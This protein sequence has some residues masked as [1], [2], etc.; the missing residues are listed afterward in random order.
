M[1][2]A[3][4]DFDASNDHIRIDAGDGR[5]TEGIALDTRERPSG[6]RWTDDEWVSRID[7][8]LRQAANVA[9]IFGVHVRYNQAWCEDRAKKIGAHVPRPD[10]RSDIAERDAYMAIHG[11]L[12]TGRPC[13]LSFCP[14]PYFATVGELDLCQEHFDQVKDNV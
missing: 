8:H 13:D 2:D 14:D 10:D 4:V 7:S 11:P 3:H 9:R 12:G 5:E 1:R 6:G